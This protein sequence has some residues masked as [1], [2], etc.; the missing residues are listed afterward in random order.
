MSGPVLERSLLDRQPVN[1]HNDILP[2]QG[3]LM[4]IDAGERRVGLALSD[5]TQTLARPLAVIKRRSRAEDF[6][7]I[8]HLVQE[9]DVVGLVVGH[10]LHADGSAGPQARRSARYGHRLA[11]A[12]GLPVVLRDEY[13]SSKEAARLRQAGRRPNDSPLDAEAAAVILQAYLDEGRRTQQEDIG[14]ESV[15][16][17]VRHGG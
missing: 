17:E 4:A 5:E 13:G 15:I 10:P 16:D 1:R 12:L 14:T 9:H 2:Q 7:Q 11:S 6:S 3:R 8:G